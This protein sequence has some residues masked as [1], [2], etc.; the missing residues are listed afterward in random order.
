M[1]IT[2]LLSQGVGTTILGVAMKKAIRPIKPASFASPEEKRE[3]RQK[4]QEYREKISYTTKDFPKLR[5]WVIFARSPEGKLFVCGYNR[6]VTSGKAYVYSLSAD[7]KWTNLA[8]GNGSLMYREYK[9]LEKEQV[10]DRVDHFLRQFRLRAPNYKF[11]V[12]RVGSKNWPKEARIVKN[13]KREL[14]LDI[15]QQ[16][17]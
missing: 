17:I 10:H 7:W 16:R 11:F 8:T 1:C 15:D 2:F 4:V 13:G 9:R 3:Y 14:L 6:V 5:K 12:S